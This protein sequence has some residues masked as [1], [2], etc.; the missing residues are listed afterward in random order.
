MYEFYN[1]HPDILSFLCAK[2][3][4]S[5]EDY[6]FIMQAEFGS[7]KRLLWNDKVYELM[8]SAGVKCKISSMNRNCVSMS[9]TAFSELCSTIARFSPLSM[10]QEA[11][12]QWAIANLGYC[13][14]ISIN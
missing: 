7:E 4:L 13:M 14:F 11:V 6:K 8:Q 3:L 1:I 12:K 2:W 5:Y 9:D 10:A